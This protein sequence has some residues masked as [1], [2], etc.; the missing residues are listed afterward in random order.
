MENTTFTE[1]EIELLNSTLT[2]IGAL[3][4]SANS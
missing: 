4:I 2:Q 1:V 3:I